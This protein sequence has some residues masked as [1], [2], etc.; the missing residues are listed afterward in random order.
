MTI[1]TATANAQAAAHLVAGLVD[2][3]V[4]AAVISPGSRNTPLVLALAA[5]PKITAHLIISLTRHHVGF[6]HVIRQ[7]LRH[8][9][10]QTVTHRRPQ[11]FIDLRKPVDAD[12]QHRPDYVRAL[13]V[14]QRPV[15]NNIEALAVGQS[16]Q[17]VA[18][19]HGRAARA[20]RQQ[21]AHA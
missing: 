17:R 16:S 19:R 10:K 7:P 13:G 3:G 9:L 1:E 11:R 15:E 8:S 18:F 6:A 5:H 20:V 21:I 2:A 4:R 12:L 14:G